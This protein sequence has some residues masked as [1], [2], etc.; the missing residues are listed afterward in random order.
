MLFER[1][2][3]SNEENNFNQRASIKVVG[4]GGGG[5]N[6]LDRMIDNEVR[7]VEFIAINTDSQD[8]ANS[9][10]GTRVQIGKT[11]ARGLGAGANPIKGRNAA[12]E[13]EEQIKQVLKGA[14][15][16][17][18]TCGMGGGTGTGASP[19]VAR[20]ANELGC[21]TVG[22]VTK[23]FT[24]EGPER[25]T[26]ALAG[27][28][29]IKP[30]L[31]TLI[32]IPNQ[33]LLQIVDPSTKM[34]QCF[35]EADNVLRQG[36]QAISE[37]INFASL[38][39][40]DFADVK[41]IM[42]GKGTALMG[43][44]IAKGPTRA[45]EA[46]RNAITSPLLEVSI[47]GATNAIVNISSSEDITMTEV[48]QLISE[49]RNNCDKNLNIIWGVTINNDLGDELVV[50]VIATGYELKQKESD[51]EDLTN[52]LFKSVSSNDD[53][54]DV[55]QITEDSEEIDLLDD[56]SL[57]SLFQNP[58]A[59]EIRRA[60]IRQA[61]EDAKRRKLEEKAMKKRSKQ[62]FKGNDDDD[63]NLPDWLQS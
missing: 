48:D 11:L 43:I 17:F 38:I 36:V 5:G 15:M 37:L 9:K 23:P 12:L 56:G 14:D 30:Y 59:K 41:T 4:V 25:M 50:T 27:I 3:G 39:N 24:F 7:G 44:G 2:G 18:I 60:Q 10:A 22:I 20:I 34:L 47:D 16:V 13:S 1:Q 42:K 26:N 40:V 51:M 53:E 52:S 62:G 21:L 63:D 8:L 55:P 35:R 54:L 46:A 58:N 6:A 29:A 33:R 19:V 45:I 61:K 57:D 32:I 31:D 28:E 49:I